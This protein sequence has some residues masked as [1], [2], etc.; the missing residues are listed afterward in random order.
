MSKKVLVIGSGP[1]GYPAALKLASLG[2]E[3]TVAE[4]AKAGGVCLNCGCIPSKSLLDAAHKFNIVRELKNLS[5]EPQKADAF[6]DTMDF[7]KI[8]ARRQAAVDK[9]QRGVLTLLKAAKVNYVQGEAA[10]TSPNSA[11]ING[12][13][14]NFDAAIIACGTKAFYPPPFDKYK[15]HLYDNSNIFSITALPKRAAIIGG[16][17]IGCEFACIFNALGVDTTIIELAPSILPMEDESISRVLKNSFEKRGIKI[18]TSAAAKDMEIKDGIKKIILNDGQIIEA[19]LVLAAIGRTPDLAGLNLEAAGIEYDSKGIKVNPQTMKV[20]NNIYA[21][22][23]V[24]RLCQ[25][26]HAAT[27]QGEAAALDIMG[28]NAKYN[29]DLVP[30]AVYTWPEI[31]SVGL[32]LK[33]ALEKGYEAKAKKSFMLANGRAVTQGESEGFVQIVEDTKTG[34]VLGAQIIGPCASEMIHLP[35]TAMSFGIKAKDIGGQIFA[36][37]TVSEAVK[38]ALL[39]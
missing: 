3:V 6:F 28:F 1:A 16:G 8:Q 5:G 15:Q 21:A 37:P 27:A 33:Q 13:E 35:L 36:H 24:N 19:D 34:L 2:A 29:N 32:T 25:L 26:A 22:G 9:L 11:K 31:S 14:I 18:I 12:Q 4:K 20:K 10:F 7:T 23:D 39:K 38:E 30:R 17:F